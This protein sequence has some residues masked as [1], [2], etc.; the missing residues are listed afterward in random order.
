MSSTSGS[1]SSLIILVTGC[2]S[3]I[4]RDL[5]KQLAHAGYTVVATARK[6]ETLADLPV[7]LKLHLDVT[8]SE[9]I[10][11]AIN[12]TI[13]RFGRIDVLVNNAGY[14]LRG[15]IEEIS[16]IQIQQIFDVNVF[17]ALRMIRAVIPHMRKQNTGR[18]INISSIVGK[19]PMPVNG[20]YSATKFALEALSDALRLELAS[21]G[22]HVVLI[23]PGNIKTNFLETAE[24][25]SKKI[26]SN[27]ESPYRALY[28]QAQ[29]VTD[30]MRHQEPEPEVV[31]RVIKQVIEN[32]TPKA[33]YL[34]A[35]P[36]SGLLVLHMGDSI[37]E[38][39]LRHLFKIRQIVD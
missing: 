25:H 27:P 33:R 19:L 12:D 8:Q 2:S 5:V 16:D 18:I 22:I 28:Q 20:P 37:W 23:E 36:F 14:A 3:G 4:G 11:R 1:N 21:F 34:A 6:V 13:Q 24:N 39:I 17:G 26:I 35:V 38:A 15:A 9:S 30:S 32:P 7:E 31:S 29:T 10:T